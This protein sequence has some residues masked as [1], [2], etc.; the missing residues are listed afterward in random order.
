MI[1]Y[2]Y[3]FIIAFLPE[4]EIEVIGDKG[5]L[6]KILFGEAEIFRFSWL[7]TAFAV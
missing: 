1:K 2:V 5:N 7:F 3:Y 4:L 6:I